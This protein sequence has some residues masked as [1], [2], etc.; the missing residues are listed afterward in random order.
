VSLLDPSQLHIL[1]H[2]LLDIGDR[3]MAAV[4]Q[5]V[6]SECSHCV[7]NVCQLV[8][9]I[10]IKDGKQV[11]WELGTVNVQKT[12]EHS[13]NVVADRGQALYTVDTCIHAV[14]CTTPQDRAYSALTSCRAS[15]KTLFL[16]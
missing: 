2:N 10:T 6:L 5:A 11:S 3:Y 7:D 15:Y 9:L 12:V 16:N 1:L 4:W 13:S 8:L 14:C